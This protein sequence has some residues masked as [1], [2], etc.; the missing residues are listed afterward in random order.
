M[1]AFGASDG[2]NEQNDYANL[3]YEALKIPTRY[4]GG[5]PS[6]AEDKLKDILGT[7]SEETS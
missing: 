2:A 3:F 4:E 6:V 7:L 5:K 1:L